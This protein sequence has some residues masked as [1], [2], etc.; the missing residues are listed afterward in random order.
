MPSQNADYSSSPSQKTLQFPLTLKD[1]SLTLATAVKLAGPIKIIS[2]KISSPE[3]IF[4]CIL[5]D[6]RT[7]RP[8]QTVRIAVDRDIAAFRTLNSQNDKMALGLSGT[9]VALEYASF[10]DGQIRPGSDAEGA[11]RYDYYYMLTDHLGS[12]RMVVKDKGNQL[13]EAV[14]YAPYGKMVEEL[15]SSGEKDVREKFTGKEYD[16]DGS[17]NGGTGIGLFYFGARY[18]DADVGRWVSTDPAEQFWDLYA[19]AGN[20]FN[21][22]SAIDSDGNQL[23]VDDY[24]LETNPDD[25]REIDPELVPSKWAAI[26]AS[27]DFFFTAQLISSLKSFFVARSAMSEAAAINQGSKAILR[28]GYYEVNGYKFSKYYYEK[29]WNTGRG[30]PSLVVEEILKATGGKGVPDALKKGF[31][32]YESGGWELV[33]NPKTMEVWHLQPVR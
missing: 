27:I 1:Q 5:N 16:T 25:P 19:Y 15:A 28:D 13:T 32:T 33:Y 26:K 4:S 11:E 24:T 10:G 20:G 6:G 29:L 22:I 8:G 7:F 31:F 23:A 21:P 17:G 3:D 9:S 18:Y 2:V 14:L 30:G 12:T